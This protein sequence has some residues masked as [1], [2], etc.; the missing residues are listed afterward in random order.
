MSKFIP[1]SIPKLDKLLGGGLKLGSSVVFWESPGVEGTPFIYQIL[2]NALEG[3]NS[4]IYISLSKSPEMIVNEAKVYG[5][6]LKQYE[7]LIFIDGYSG[8]FGKKSDEK[9]FVKPRN[10]RDFTKTLKRAIRALEDCKIVVCASLSVLI[11]IYGEEVLSELE[12]WKKLQT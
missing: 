9:F 10:I 5:W 6:K 4:G 7:H 12:N 1:T 8:L 3:G 11:D 2:N